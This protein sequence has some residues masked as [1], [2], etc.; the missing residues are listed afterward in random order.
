ML[1]GHFAESVL[2]GQAGD[3]DKARQTIIDAAAGL[4]GR[5][6]HALARLIDKA[7]RR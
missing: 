3:P 2:T 6:G 5:H 4:A 1:V 7:I